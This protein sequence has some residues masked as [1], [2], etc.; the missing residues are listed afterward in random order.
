MK[1]TRK[2]KINVLF[3]HQV[4]S[5]QNYGGITAYY[6]R[7]IPN[8]RKFGIKSNLSLFVSSNYQISRIKKHFFLNIPD[9][10]V[11][12]YLKYI[13][14]VVNTV[15]TYLI[16][17]FHKYDIFH[18]TYYEPYFLKFLGKKKLVVTVYDCAYEEMGSKQKWSGRLLVNR[19]KILERADK[20]IA[21]SS[22]VKKDIL[23]F[24]KVDPNKIKV[25]H[26]FS[27]LGSKKVASRNRD[28]KS[29]Q[30]IYIG[31]REFN[32][33]FTRFIR[34]FKKLSD[35]HKNLN[36]LCMGGGKFTESELSLMKKMNIA[37]KVSWKHISTDKDTVKHLKQSLMFVYPSL[38]EGFGIPLLNSFACG[39][40]VVA[41]DIPVFN[42]IAKGAFVPFDP[43]SVDNM[44][45]VMDKVVSNKI[46]TNEFIKN[47]YNCLKKYSI[48]KMASM[49]A[50]LYRGL[51]NN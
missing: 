25:I 21:I 43:K 4:F 32:K 50:K 15:Y 23:K 27:P 26:L 28:F 37:G 42:E 36:L 6:E 38:K 45:S 8:L 51:V 2:E 29:S 41:S 11:K 5:L 1:I 47:G 14:F 34:S 10:F 17:K 48:E 13:Y 31:T 49:S 12:K 30:I 24:Y 33:N 18:A 44:F 7:L 22:D 19:K 9:R 35:K 46:D 16:F 39:C 3:D 40:L 20:I